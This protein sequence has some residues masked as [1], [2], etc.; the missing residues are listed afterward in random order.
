M[1]PQFL[2]LPDTIRIKEIAEETNNEFTLKDV[3]DIIQGRKLFI[4]N[5]KSHLTPYKQISFEISV[6]NKENLL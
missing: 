4:P 3:K 6:L 2:T 5:Y 1:L